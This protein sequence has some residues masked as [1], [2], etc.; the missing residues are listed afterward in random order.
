MSDAHHHSSVS[1]RYLTFFCTT[2]LGL[3]F[4]LGVLWLLT[5]GTV[6]RAGAAR[7]VIAIFPPG[8]VPEDAVDLLPA[9]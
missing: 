4:L 1:R 8:T 3:A 6:S 5:V 7:P 2:L 9:K